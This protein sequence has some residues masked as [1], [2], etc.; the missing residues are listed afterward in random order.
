[1]GKEPLVFLERE[2]M[3]VGQ[4]RRQGSQWRSG[5]EMVEMKMAC[6]KAVATPSREKLTGWRAP[7]C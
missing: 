4:D 7:R 2:K 1:M 5:E 6:T 3:R